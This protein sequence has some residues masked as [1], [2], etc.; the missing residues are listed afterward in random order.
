MQL[1]RREREGFMPN[2]WVG[3]RVNLDIEE[4]YTR[5]PKVLFISY[6]GF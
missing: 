3:V 1:L 2:S 4:G 6:P 5:S